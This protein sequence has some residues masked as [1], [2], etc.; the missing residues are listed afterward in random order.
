M[1]E[2]FAF[3]KSV[4]DVVWSGVL[5]SV[6]TLSG[7]FLTNRSHTKRLRIQL[8]ADAVEKDKERV[9]NM[10]REVYL[11]AAEELTRAMNYLTSLP[12]RDFTALNTNEEL[13]EFFAS[14]SKLQLV[15]EPQ[16][17]LLAN[18]LM[19]L[20]SDVLLRIFE[21]AIPLQEARSDIAI[22]DSFLTQSQGHVTR[23]LG[24]MERF[25]T[26]E[27]TGIK[28]FEALNESLKFHQ[29][30]AELHATEHAEAWDRYNSH[31]V[32]LLKYIIGELRPLADLQIPLV[33][34]IRKDLG[35]T[36]DLSAWE[37]QLR[38]QTSR[39]YDQLSD[40]LDRLM[41]KIGSSADTP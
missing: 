39:M 38:E 41:N 34:A 18:K 2:I 13:K 5:A 12:Q 10:R 4:P 17:A 3:L 25:N 7:V 32:S 11:K 36:A 6:I 30:Q 40:F 20:Y 19:A 24:E 15:S 27:N 29:D 9:S 1:S 33:L 16:T 21:A 35:L 22:S 14:S 28:S 31:S 23:L 26:S 37:A 8:Q